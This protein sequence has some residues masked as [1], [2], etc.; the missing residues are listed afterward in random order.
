MLGQRPGARCA[1]LFA[2]MVADGTAFLKSERFAPECRVFKRS[3]DARYLG[4]NFEVRVDCDGL[5]PDDLEVLK[6]RFHAAHAKEYGYDIRERCIEFV[7]ARLKAVGQV[8]RVT[9]PEVA[10]G[11]SLESRRTR[12]PG[13]IFRRHI[14][15][16]RD[17]ALR[18]GS[19]AGRCS[20]QR[21]CD[22]YRNECHHSFVARP[23]RLHGRSRQSNL[24]RSAM[25][26]DSHC[27]SHRYGSFLK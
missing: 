18:S 17:S 7:S 15:L 25:T 10:G 1:G 27:R 26:E 8:A 4:Q 12:D 11:P 16:V 2:E 13:G 6:E 22:Y 14:G 5:G 24:A 3:L 9:A 19:I 20:N 21:P 23:E